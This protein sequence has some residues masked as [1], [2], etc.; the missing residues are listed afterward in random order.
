MPLVCRLAVL[1]GLMAHAASGIAQK[2]IDCAASAEHRA[3]DFWVGDWIVRDS[4]GSVLG[5]NQIRPIQKAC[6]LEEQWA[7]MNG[8]T[9]QS[10]NFY[11][12][13]E[14]RWR[15]IWTDAGNSIIDIR[16]GLDGDSMLLEGKIFYLQNGSE[17]AFRGRWIPLEDGRVQQVFHE[18]D[19][20]G[21]WQLW[22]EGYYTRKD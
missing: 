14:G 22:F 4:G 10:V 15:Q 21:E 18:E 3:F 13:G 7:S 17:R 2:P 16:G 5:H 8:G 20:K 6:A 11:H 19:D 9:G 1:I 12:P